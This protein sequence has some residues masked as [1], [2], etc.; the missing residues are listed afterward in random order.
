MI[1]TYLFDQLFIQK[2]YE[3]A[4]LFILSTYLEMDKKPT[5]ENKQKF[6]YIIACLKEAEA[7]TNDQEEIKEIQKIWDFLKEN[8]IQIC[9]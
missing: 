6:N 2:K 4:S 9:N 3:E 5:E 7:K 8:N 1:L